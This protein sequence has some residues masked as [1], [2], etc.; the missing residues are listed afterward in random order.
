MPLGFHDNDVLTSVR[1]AVFI[2]PPETLI[3]SALLAKFTTDAESVGDGDTAF[4]TIGHMS[5]DNL[6]ESNMDGGDATVMNTWNKKGFRTNYAD[7]TATITL[8]A[9]QCDKDLLKLV[10]DGVD[11]AD[12]LGVAYSIEK[13]PANKSVAILVHDTNTDRR[14]LW[15][16]PNTDLTFDNLITLNHDSFNQID[17][18][19]TLKPSDAL[20]KKASGKSNYVIYYSPDDF[21]TA[22]GK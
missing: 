12:Q 13:T 7:T 16:Y 21:A 1:G 9:V 5:E 2:A 15:L 19:G 8:H 4:V 17:I 18:L 3:T 6:P 20:P 10:Y 14:A 11:G 22:A